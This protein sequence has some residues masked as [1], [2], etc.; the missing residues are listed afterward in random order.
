VPRF[1]HFL[2]LAAG[3]L[4]I[5]DG[6]H[7]AEAARPETTA[8]THSTTAYRSISVE[9][10]SIFYRE[11]GSPK[12]PT[13][14]L[15]HGLPSSSRMFDTL[16]PLLAGQYHVVAPDYPGFGRSD[17]PPPESF[18]YTFDHIAAVMDGFTRAL[19]LDRY[20]LY[21][22]DYGGPVGFRLAL[23]HP[24]RVTALVIQN[25]VAYDS[26]PGDKSWAL[27]RAFWADRAAHEEQIRA[28]MIAPETARL[29]HVGTSPHPER[30]DPDL[31]ADDLAFLARPGEDRIQLDLSYDYRTNVASYPAWQAYLR[32]HRP[33]TLVVWGRYDA[34][35]LVA[36]AQAYRYDVPNAEIH[37]LDAGHFAL[38]EAVD[39]ISRDMRVFLA[40]HVA[41]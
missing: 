22:Q 24:E 7:A 16:I 10:L 36:G 32:Q 25:A 28:T 21:V 18:A 40:R 37:I 15:L 20:A 8:A 33:P 41:R 1:F 13:I 14:V 26:G 31:W 38:G 6:A 4:A 19:G 9:G 12:A 34:S 11:A 3:I 5:A 30:I 29:R 17:A 35:F 27:R 23:A 2:A 39:E